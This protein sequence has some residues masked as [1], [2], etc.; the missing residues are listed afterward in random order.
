[1]KK[2]LELP[3]SRENQTQVL[4]YLNPKTYVALLLIVRTVLNFDCIDA[5]CCT[6][7]V[8]L[9]SSL[10]YTATSKTTLLPSQLLIIAVS[11]IVKTS[12]GVGKM[13]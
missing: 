3:N 2:I 13:V 12:V 4:Q 6:M 7:R 9:T 5:S 1:M 8:F 11:L 10:P